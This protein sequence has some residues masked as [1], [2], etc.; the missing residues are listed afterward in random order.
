[1]V[2]DTSAIAAIL[3]GEPEAAA[4]AGALAA[5]PRRLASAVSILEAGIVIESRKGPAGAR[6]LDVLV[7]RL[8]VDVVPFTES[9]A[10]VA[11]A[12]WRKYGK[13]R[14]PAGL[15]IGDCAAYALAKTSGEMLLCKGEDFPR[16]DA[17]LVPW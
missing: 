8:G 15:N 13:G 10:E 9:Q 6:E 7:H 17:R 3:L 11:R 12:A 1:M 16:T 5:D 14:H 4:I 2:I